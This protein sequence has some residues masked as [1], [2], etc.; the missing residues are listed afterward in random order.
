MKRLLLFAVISIFVSPLYAQVTRTPVSQGYPSLT[1]Y[2]SQFNDAFSLRSNAASLAGI[3]RFSA[4]IFSERRFLLQALSSYS[5]AVALPASSGNFG[6]TGDYFGDAS[7]NETSVGLAYGRKLGKLLDIGVKFDYFNLQ[8]SG[9]GSAA[10]VSF[11]AGV[12]LHPTPAVQTGFAVHHP[13]GMKMGKSGDEKLPAVYSVG[14]GYD[15][16]SQLFVGAEVEKTEDQP[17]TLNV[18]LHYL[19]A[20]KLIARGGI[21]SATSVYYLGFGV[22]MKKFRLDVTASIHPYLGTTPGL[23]LIYSAEK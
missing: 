17:V 9:Y 1:T 21:S 8:A 3:Q 10:T 16:S 13:I 12:I 22:Q 20:N 14:V 4:G 2:S 23:L 5:L 15:V 11:D 7:F 6:V 19:I 18:G